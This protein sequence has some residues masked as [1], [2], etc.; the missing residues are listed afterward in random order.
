MSEITQSEFNAMLETAISQG[1]PGGYITSR[2]SWEEIEAILAGGLGQNTVPSR[3]ETVAA[4]NLPAY[5]NA[6]PRLLTE[7][8]TIEVEPG[9]LTYSNISGFY[10]PGSLVIKKG[11]SSSSVTVR[12]AV[13][14]QN[15]SIL[16]TF[17]GIDF[18]GPSPAGAYFSI[19]N[20]MVYAKNMSLTG[21]NIANQLA[22]NVD[23]GI[24]SMDSTSFSAF[25]IAVLAQRCGAIDLMNCSGAGNTVGI[26][27]ALGGVIGLAGTTPDLLGGA[28]NEK[29]GG[30]IIKS[31][32]TLL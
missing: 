19:N 22:V 3:T 7:N 30:I 13:F 24:L 12:T 1:L 28:T 26:Q 25:V 17:D 5:I 14:V 18:Q 32:G 31:N 27:S 15:C 2:W 9:E 23:R 10:G 20:S 6:L 16:L 4:A 21:T 29:K 8:L 11:N